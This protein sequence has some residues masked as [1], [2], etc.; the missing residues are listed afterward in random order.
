VT[1]DDETTRREA[2]LVSLGGGPSI[3]TLCLAKGNGVV[4]W[5]L[6]DSAGGTGRSSLMRGVSVALV[7][8]KGAS[9][10]EVP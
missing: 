9:R 3:E 6:E 4:D 10:G 8:I 2:A 5:T 1:P 7:S